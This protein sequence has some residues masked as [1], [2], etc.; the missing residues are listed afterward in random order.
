[1]NSEKFNQLQCKVIS[2]FVHD[3]YLNITAIIAKARMG[4][5]HMLTVRMVWLRSGEHLTLRND[6]QN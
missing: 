2:L 1:M 3:N 5:K 4:T 6:K